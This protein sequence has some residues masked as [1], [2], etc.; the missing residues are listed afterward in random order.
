MELMV[1]PKPIFSASKEVKGY[2]LSFQVGNALLEEGTAR[3]LDLGANSRLF[4][5]VNDIGL[6]VLTMNKLI[7]IP[8]TDVLLATDLESSCAVDRSLVVLM[9]N[10]NNQLSQANLEKIAY[11]KDAGFQIAFFSYP[12]IGA[13]EPFFPYIDFVFSNN[14]TEIMMPTVKYIKSHGHKAKVIATKVD[15]VQTFDRINL[16]GIPLFAGHFYK[17]P[18][19]SKE[20][21][22]SPLQVNY[23][24]LLN[25]ISQD[26]FEF[27]K[28]TK[29]VQR[30]TALAIHFLK[31]VNST[32]GRSNKITSL[33][34]A[35]A[36]V[37]ANEIKRWITTAVSS[38]LSQE[39][40]G[41]I[42]RMSLLRAKFCENISGLFDMAIHSDNLFLMGL[43]SVL[44]VILDMPIDK[45]LDLVFVPDPVRVALTGGS[46][47][48]AM[49]YTFVK[50]YEQGDWTEI[51]R[52]ALIKNLKIKDIYK[53][54]YDALTWYGRLISMTVDEDEALSSDEE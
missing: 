7:F 18:M 40:P 8:V 24:Q 54:Y 31:M 44:D 33:R 29:V 42:T 20:S 2:Y 32:H 48:F 25:Q 34:H 26:D 36:M 21:N 4:N 27:D 47:D 17:V 11:L 45:A 12:S 10:K 19:A 51:S 50:E 6:D 22:V 23:I 39:K 16:F 3:A 41:E 49:I 28:F 30:D 38:T 53:A 52:T 43:F 5:F 35:A 14:D 46:N 13:V 1:V 15:S 9:I 37:G